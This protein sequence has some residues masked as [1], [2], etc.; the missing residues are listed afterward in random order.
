MLTEDL[1]LAIL[2]KRHN[3]LVTCLY[4]IDSNDFEKFTLLRKFIQMSHYRALPDVTVRSE[5]PANL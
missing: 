5:S 4:L 2:L 1:E 3:S